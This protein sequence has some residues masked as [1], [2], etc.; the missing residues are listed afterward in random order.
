M[1][2]VTIK[3]VCPHAASA[4]KLNAQ[5]GLRLPLTT[6]IK[7]GITV[8]FQLSRSSKIFVSKSTRTS[9]THAAIITRLFQPTFI[10]IFFNFSSI[11]I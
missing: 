9:A 11:P 8:K 10:L 5:P 7:L 2:V 4:R 1:N 3:N 6:S